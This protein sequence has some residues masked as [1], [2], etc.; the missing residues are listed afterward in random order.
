MNKNK[1]K[2]EKNIVLQEFSNKVWK[3]H[4]STKHPTWNSFKLD[5]RQSKENECRG[6]QYAFV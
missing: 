4:K 3:A 5:N 1:T 2:K 6:I